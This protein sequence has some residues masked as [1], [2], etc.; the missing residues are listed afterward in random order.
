MATLFKIVCVCVIVAASSLT[1]PAFFWSNFHF[2]KGANTYITQSVDQSSI[3]DFLQG[4]SSAKASHIFNVIEAG[5][6]PGFV[7]SILVEDRDSLSLSNI[8]ASS[9]VRDAGVL[10][11]VENRVHSSES[12]LVIPSAYNSA[13]TSLEALVSGVAFKSLAIGPVTVV[14]AKQ[15]SLPGVSSLAGSELQAALKS[16]AAT[17]QSGAVPVLIVVAADAQDASRI[18]ASAEAVL[19]PVARGVFLLTTVAEASAAP[20]A[21]ALAS[22]RSLLQANGTSAGSARPQV[23]MTPNVLN[24]L[25]VGGFVFFVLLFAFGCLMQIH[26]SNKFV[27]E[28]PQRGKEY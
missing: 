5:E 20:P 26:G 24:A 14:S 12:S 17:A 19:F 13:E 6:K 15:V 21:A 8:K 27:K 16:V 2:F 10:A 4:F 25:I 22:G 9:E 18:A 3:L 11:W 7:V 23:F 28:Y 1:S